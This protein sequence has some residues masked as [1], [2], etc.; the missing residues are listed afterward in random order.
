[1]PRTYC[2][3]IMSSRSGVLYIGVTG[4]LERRVRQHRNGHNDGFTKRYRCTALVY[5]EE[6]QY[7]EAALAREKQVK[8]W[9]R[10]KKMK[11]ILTLN[12]AWKD[13]AGEVGE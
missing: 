7:V 5:F 9:A 10:Q 4:N 1:M 12:P 13:L 6:F 11:L 2:V 8:T 3:Y